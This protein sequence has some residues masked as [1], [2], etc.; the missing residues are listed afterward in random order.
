MALTFRKNLLLQTS[1]STPEIFISKRQPLLE[2]LDFF[3]SCLNSSEKSRANAAKNLRRREDFIISRGLSRLMLAQKLGCPPSSLVIEV[4]VCGRPHLP[5]DDFF[6]SLSH[7]ADAIALAISKE[8]IALDI[9]NLQRERNF[10]PIIKSYFNVVMLRLIKN[11]RNKKKAFY[12]A[13]VKHEAWAKYNSA[14]ALRHNFEKIPPHHLHRIIF[15]EYALCAASALPF[16]RN[17]RLRS[18][19]VSHL[20]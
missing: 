4:D 12:K 14:S 10:A 1:L 11:S 2:Q 17:F 19:R 8:N 3:F 18:V 15:G 9:E 13:W 5:N 7:S 16:G 6:Y 20:Y